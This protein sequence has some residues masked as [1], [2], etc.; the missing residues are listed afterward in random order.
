MAGRGFALQDR[1][2]CLDMQAQTAGRIYII[3]L[4]RFLGAVA[5]PGPSRAIPAQDMAKAYCSQTD[6]A[7]S[8]LSQD[9]E[10]RC[11]QWLLSHASPA[12]N[13]IGLRV[14]LKARKRM[15]AARLGIAPETFARAQAVAG[16]WSDC[17]AGQ[18]H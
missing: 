13:G 5:E 18:C 17:R 12:G 16:A 8:R 6:L 9:A 15:I 10:A 2:S 11:A 3:P 1:P 4:A 14:T 7:V